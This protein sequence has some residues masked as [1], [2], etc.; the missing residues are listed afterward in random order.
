MYISIKCDKL[1]NIMIHELYFISYSLLSL[2]LVCAI[3]INNFIIIIILIMINNDTSFD[4]YKRLLHFHYILNHTRNALTQTLTILIPRI[5]QIVSHF[6]HCIP[7]DF[8]IIS[9]SRPTVGYGIRQ[10]RVCAFFSTRLSYWR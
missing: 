7:V 1:G 10:N 3:F 2:I 4:K 6:W 9:F 8:R 5:T